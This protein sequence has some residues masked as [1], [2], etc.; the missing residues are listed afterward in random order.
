MV[1]RLCAWGTLRLCVE[2]RPRSRNLTW[3]RQRMG[4]SVSHSR[5]QSPDSSLTR[6]PVQNLDLPPLCSPKY[7]P[8]PP[9]DDAQVLSSR[10]NEALILYD[11]FQATLHKFRTFSHCL[12]QTF[13]P[14]VRCVYSQGSSSGC[15]ILMQR[16][17]TTT[18]MCST[19]LCYPWL[20]L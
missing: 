13:C 3:T 15:C 9:S 17:S 16:V 19:L 7:K 20:L 2:S 8:G 11:A 5:G 14:Q 10:L 12:A 4:F 18:A 1:R 6:F